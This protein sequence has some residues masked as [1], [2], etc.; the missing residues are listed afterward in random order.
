MNFSTADSKGWTPLHAASQ[1]GALG[2]VAFL[3]DCECPPDA[4]A[5]DIYGWTAI[6][7]ASQIGHLDTVKY[8][9]Q[10]HLAITTNGCGIDA[11]RAPRAQQDS[12]QDVHRS[13]PYLNPIEMHK[14]LKKY[15]LQKKYFWMRRRKGIL[16]LSRNVS[17][18]A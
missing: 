12:L 4:T 9:V 3:L 13:A 6:H 15:I 18:L 7:F 14:K 16:L 17:P 2:V 8:L 5:K 10:E 11:T 1:A